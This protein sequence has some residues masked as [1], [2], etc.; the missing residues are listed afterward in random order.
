ME[1]DSGG[2]GVFSTT[3]QRE[4]QAERPGALEILGHLGKPAELPQSSEEQEWR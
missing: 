1:W 3:S 4:P 2:A